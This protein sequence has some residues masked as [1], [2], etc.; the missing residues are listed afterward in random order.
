MAYPKQ[1]RCARC[2]RAVRENGL[3]RRHLDDW[4]ASGRSLADYLAAVV[5]DPPGRPIPGLDPG[6]Y[7]IEETG[8]V[9]A[10][11]R[12]YWRKLPVLMRN[13]TATVIVP[14]E[15]GK[16][17]PQRLAALVLRTFVG[18][19]PIGHEPYHFPDPDPSNNAVANL[20][21][22]PIGT[23]KLGRDPLPGRH[24]DERGE[25]NPSAR[26]TAEDIPE[27]R[28]MYRRGSTARDIALEC[29]VSDST[30]GQ[31]LR[32]VTWGHVPDPLGPVVMRPGLAR[33]TDNPR[34]KLDEVIVEEIRQRRAAGETCQALA[35]AYGV[36]VATISAVAT[37]RIWRHVT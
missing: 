34:T 25:R 4:R 28:D 35:R 30:I 29:G 27:I 8:S 9:W 11:R 32:G 14:D 15:G 26:L 6:R 37:G 17:R 24:P 1:P 5:T 16:F 13:G 2:S 36:S 3:C 23:S 20:R 33:G 10:R 12:K 19:R 18:P 22:A 31:V 21:W 7:R